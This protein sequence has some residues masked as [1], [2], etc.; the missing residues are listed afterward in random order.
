[1][2]IVMSRL[3]TVSAALL[4]TWV[5]A[6]T[7]HRLEQLVELFPLMALVAGLVEVARK[8]KLTQRSS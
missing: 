1:M 7:S 8:E 4:V 6:V 5:V 3:G 2:S